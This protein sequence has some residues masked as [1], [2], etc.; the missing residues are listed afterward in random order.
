MECLLNA[1]FHTIFYKNGLINA[2]LEL[3]TLGKY[4][5]QSDLAAENA[6]TRFS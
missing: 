2:T 6:L 1:G 4:K 5:I 3:L